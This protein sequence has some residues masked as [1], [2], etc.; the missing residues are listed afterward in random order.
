MGGGGKGRAFRSEHSATLRVSFP[1]FFGGRENQAY[2]DRR[3]MTGKV[4][5]LPTPGNACFGLSNM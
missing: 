2:G 4:S 5:P 3:L 1:E